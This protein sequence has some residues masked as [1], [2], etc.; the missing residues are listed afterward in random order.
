[1]P[2]RLRVLIALI[3]GLAPSRSHATHLFGADIYYTHVSGNTYSINLAAYGDCSGSPLA[4]NGLYTATPEIQI[5]NNGFHHQTI[6]LSATSTGIEVTPVC[7]SQINNTTCNGGTVPGVRR[8]IYSG[9]V[10]L[11]PSSSWLFRFTGEFMNNTVAGRSNTI[12]NIFSGTLMSLEATL[13]NLNGPNSSATYTTI[14][15]P[16]FCINKPAQY[17]PGAVDPNN[18]GLSFALV[19]GLVQGGFPVTYIAPFTAAQPLATAPTTFS[20]STS[21]GQLNFTPNLVQNALVVG[22]VEEY[23]NGVMVGS[24]MREMTFVVLNNCNNNPPG[25]SIG[26]PIGGV[27][28]NPNTVRVCA[29]QSNFSYNITPADLDGNNITITYA[30]LP[31]GASLNISG[32]GTN[33]PAITFSWNA[34]NVAPGNYTFFITYTDDGCPLAS[35]QT[36]AYTVVVAPKPNFTYSLVQGA[37][38]FKKGIF[39]VSPIGTAPFSLTTYFGST[40][41][42]SISNISNPQID[43]LPPNTFTVRVTDGIGCFRDTVVTVSPPPAIIAGFSKANPTCAGGNNGSITA[44][45]SAGQPPFQYA[46]GTGPYSSSPVFNN[47]AAGTYTLRVKDAND[48]TKDTTVVLVVPPSIIPSATIQR[49]VCATLANGSVSLS[50]TNGAAPYQYAVGSG[51]YSASPVFSPLAAGSYVFHVKDNNGCIKDTTI[52]ITDS[53]NIAGTVTVSNVLCINESNGSFTVTP[54]GGTSPYTFAIGSSAFTSTNSFTNLAAGSYNLKI[55]DANGCIKDTNILVSQP[56]ALRVT[57]SA[58][59]PSCHGGNDGEI[60]LSGTGGTPGYTYALDAGPFS[61]TNAFS[62]LSKGSYILHVKDANG[63]TKDTVVVLNEPTP[64]QV[65]VSI[66]DPK[67]AGEN[68]GFVVVQAGGGTPNYQY[69]ADGGAFQTS[70]T[71]SGLNAGPHLIQVMDN[72]GCT[73]DTTITLSEPPQLVFGSF[74]ITHPTCEGYTDGRVT[75]S[76]LGGTL[77]YEFALGTG[78]FGSSPSFPQLAAGSYLF[79]IRDHNNCLID[80]TLQLTGYPPIIIDSFGIKSASCFGATDGAITVHA[81]GGNQP[82]MFAL[83]GGQFSLNPVF[84]NLTS[85][86]HLIEIEDAKGCKKDSLVVVPAPQVLAINPRVTHN[87]CIGLD[88]GGA[89]QAVVTGGTEPY[90]YAWSTVPEQHEQTATGLSNGRYSV[91]VEDVN[92]CSDTASAEV[93]YD[94]CCTVFVPD[95]FT[96][97]NDGRNDNVKVSYKGDMEL[98]EFAIYNRFGEK[99]FTA[100]NRNSHWDGYHNGVPQEVGTYFYYLQVI[101]GNKRTNIKEFKGDII[102]I[103]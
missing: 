18:D 39:Q 23:R 26:N 96:P 29:S 11:A 62:G 86:A 99:V 81:S 31:V 72:N 33:S 43:S 82:L 58:T 102:L 16:F 40:I 25:G 84:S 56:T 89:V 67:C 6:Y 49:P 64:L 38:C 71:L 3:L 4:F 15:T 22:K 73:N 42:H 27:L 66:S 7:P 9:T 51:P 34:S 10:T 101:C 35:K 5:F 95:A 100:I 1:M 83:D 65:S 41:F 75:I 88:D 77:P 93:T 24:S 21:T 8:F 45:P 90:T 50:A 28:I 76:G 55:K 97:N 14:P 61:P 17:N 60:Q 48:C 98:L 47:L 12:T 36:V 103:R 20:F 79:S 19:P 30:G 54:F 13:N 92:G 78:S 2:H 94:D 70:S 52:T 68:S 53:L 91:R 69:A 59:E 63:C 74:E 32:N 85:E 37:T 44:A 57:V 80:T 46:L 87:D